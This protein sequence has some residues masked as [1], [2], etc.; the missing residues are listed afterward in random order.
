MRG[1]MFRRPLAMF[2]GWDSCRYQICGRSHL[3]CN[4]Y[5]DRLVLHKG[6]L[7]MVL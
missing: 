2:L 1:L 5:F 6:Y 7:K 3:V 4:L